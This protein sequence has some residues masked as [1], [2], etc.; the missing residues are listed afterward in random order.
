VRKT[1]TLLAMLALA[2]SACTTTKQHAAT[3]FKPPQGSYD[4]IVMRPD[5]AVSLLTAGG[6]LE[7]REDWTNTA[8]ENVLVAIRKQQLSRGGTT[9]VALTREDAG[10][11]PEVV[12][13]LE[14]LHEVVGQSIKLHKYNPYA[15]LPTKKDQLDW[16][17]GEQAV[18]YGKASGYEYAL[19]LFARDSFSSGGRQALQALGFLGCAVGVCMMPGGGLQ[20]GFVSLVDL[21]SGKVVWFNYLLS[22]VGDIR[23]TAGAN[24]LVKRLVAGMNEE[25][26]GKR[27]S[28]K[29]NSVKKKKTA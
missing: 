2:C 22:E 19:F 14:R 7:Q 29:K 11:A 8:R 5:I 26:T 9:K 12:L 1:V 28:G 25:P 20:Q 21:K 6:T 16:T 27:T 4:I 15:Q 3:D 23:T 10:A 18:N 24:D 17:L 13:E